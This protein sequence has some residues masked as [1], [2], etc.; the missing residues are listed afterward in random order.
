MGFMLHQ[1]HGDKIF[2]IRLHGM[3]LPATLVDPSYQGPA[4]MMADVLEA[5]MEVRHDQPTGFDVAPSPLAL[6]RDKGSFEYRLD[7]RLAFVDMAA[8][9]VFLAPRK[10]LRTCHWL[11][12]YVSPRM[13]ILNKPFYVAFGRRA[14]VEIKTAEDANA[15][16]ARMAE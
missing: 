4:P 10:E 13:F 7:S 15:F 5:I 11:E 12:G 16:F 14:D 1:R 8:G 6:L 2:Q 9:F 3:D